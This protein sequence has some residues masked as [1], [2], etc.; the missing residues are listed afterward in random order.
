MFIIEENSM[1]NFN[2]SPLKPTDVLQ[3]LENLGISVCNFNLFVVVCKC[4]AQ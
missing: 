4:A 2:E 1:T 3:E